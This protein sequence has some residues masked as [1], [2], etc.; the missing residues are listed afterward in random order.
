[1]WQ[2]EEITQDASAYHLSCHK[3]DCP[4]SEIVVAVA[5]G[6][7]WRNLKLL[8]GSHSSNQAVFFVTREFCFQPWQFHCGLD[9]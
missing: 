4:A 6:L 5:A 2:E 7:L 1:M 3:R 8:G 9:P